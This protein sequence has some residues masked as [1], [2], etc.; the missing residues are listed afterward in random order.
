MSIYRDAAAVR[1]AFLSEAERFANY[2]ETEA[3]LE[4][5]ELLRC[6]ES[7]ASLAEAIDDLQAQPLKV[8]YRVDRIQAPSD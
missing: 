4:L 8:G 2:G 1:A 3:M 6:F 5:L 7:C